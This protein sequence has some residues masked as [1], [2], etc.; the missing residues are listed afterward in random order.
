MPRLASEKYCTGCL[1]CHDSC[2]HDAIRLVHKSGLAYVKVDADKCV[3]CK[4]CEK[5]CPIITPVVRNN[6]DD[7]KAYG[8]WCNV[9]EYRANG[10]SGGAFA[11]LALSFFNR[12]AGKAVAV[13]A[14]L[15]DNKVKHVLIDKA[16]DIRLLMNSKYIQSDTIGIYRQVR[17]RLKDGYKVLF[18]GTPC[19][20]AG[21][22]GYLGRGKGD[23]N[24]F[25]VE[26]VC[27]GV[28]GTEALDLHLKYYHSAKIYSFRDKKEGQY[29]YASQRTTIDLNGKP[30]KIPRTDDVF[31]RIFSG[32]MLDRKSCSNCK[33]S[34]L[35][36]VADIT[37]ADFWGA[38]VDE[39]EFMKGVSLIIAN[40]AKGNGM[41]KASSDFLHKEQTTLM[42]AIRSNPNIYT[43][44]KFIQWHPIVMFPRFF[45]KMLPAKLRLAILTNRNPWRL[46]WGVYKVL[47]ILSQRRKFKQ[48]VKKYNL[49][50]R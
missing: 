32:W 14:C 2:R 48:T 39:K 25:T 45:K 35:P 20:I 37:L 12:F 34:S 4:S 16:D 13:G 18:S 6:V 47:T 11:A 17:Q 33:F 10:A 28:P 36:R 3:E 19:Q 5:A 27:H 29:W 50:D 1:A 8:G 21:L 31:Y 41:V 23:E 42:Q 46:L 43:G 44:F 38:H 24:L 30:T 26:L 7:M 49:A 22:Y 9:D 15:E 40:N